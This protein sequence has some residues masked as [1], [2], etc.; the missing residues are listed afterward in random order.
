MGIVFEKLGIQGLEEAKEDAILASLLTAD[1]ALLIGPQGTA[2]TALVECIGAAFDERCKQIS[3]EHPEREPQ[4]FDY[5]VY[6][7]SKINFEDL[8][9]FPNVAA[10]QQG[11]VEYIK[12]PQTAWGKKLLVFDEFNRQEPSRQNNIFELIRSKR[13]M[14]VPTGT[15]WIF[16]CMN[17]F[18]M[19][20]TEALDEA[21]VDRHQ[22]FIYLTRFIDMKDHNRAN[23]VKHVGGSD[24]I[25]LRFWTKEDGEFDL[26]EGKDKDG[27]FIVNEKF[28]AVGKLLTDIE[29]RA[30]KHYKTL[31]TE[32]G[33]A[34]AQFVAKFFVLIS[35]EMESKDWKVELS[36][37]R[38]GMVHRALLAYRAIDLAKCELDPRRTPRD[39]KEMFKVCLP[40]T[41]PIGIAQANAKGLDANAMNTIYSNID[42][43]SDFFANE[44]EIGKAI[45]SI[46]VIYELLTTRNIQRKIELL[47]SEV[48]ND[49]AKS[50]VWSDL[51]KSTQDVNTYEGL[52]NSITIGLIAHLMT[53]K[54]AIVPQNIQSLLATASHKAMSAT[55]LC[56]VIKLK[57]QLAF[58]EKEIQGLIDAYDNMFVKLQA[59]AL[60]EN[61]C[62]E[63]KNTTVSRGEFAKLLEQVRTECSTLDKMMKEHHLYVEER[64]PTEVSPL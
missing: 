55:A 2:K 6:D 43:F 52:R 42:A 1:P 62:E 25:G 56:N 59:K 63:Y 33:D 12:T 16:N 47:I 24:G 17:P 23:I 32:V 28:A 57:G 4:R 14:G 53:V 21:L 51:V 3:N 46:D 15:I 49:V 35:R 48:K 8:I 9:G 22:W 37:R 7:A 11:R 40:M 18:G 39:L 19:E 60:F 29:S 5:H 44:S 31:L 10:M 41:L 58:Y 27:K 30:A 26:K 34:Y 54:P 38:A 45:A 36:G 50:E 61:Y 20:G 64:V 13:L